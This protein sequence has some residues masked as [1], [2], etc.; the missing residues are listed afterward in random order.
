V[1]LG[2]GT[3]PSRGSFV[4]WVEVVDTGEELK[5]HSAN[6]LLQILGRRFF[7]SPDDALTG[8]A[9]TENQP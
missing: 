4:G 6:E 1:R 2:P 5:F 3:N 9:I 8:G 7:Q